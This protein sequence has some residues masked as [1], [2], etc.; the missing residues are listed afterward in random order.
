MEYLW[1]REWDPLLH[2]FVL[3]IKTSDIYVMVLKL[4]TQYVFELRVFCF[5]L[6]L[7]CF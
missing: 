2:P 4:I 1:L 5:G 7:S 3:R 6:V